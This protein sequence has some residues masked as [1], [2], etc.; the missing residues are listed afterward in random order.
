LCLSKYQPPDFPRIHTHGRGVCA[1]IVRA[2]HLGK[3]GRVIETPAAEK[4]P[5]LKLLIVDD[6]APFRRLMR[7]LFR[8][9]TA[10]VM[11]CAD[12]GEAVRLYQEHR[13]DWVFMDIKMEPVNGLVA[14]R[15]IMSQFPAARVVVVTLHDDPDLRSAALAAG[16]HAFVLKDNLIELVRILPG[17]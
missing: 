4:P 6:H 2:A 13:P 16:V 12:G 1:S 5:T 7:S 11:E 8:A 17:R 14:A 9:Q 10:Q 3:A 15:Q